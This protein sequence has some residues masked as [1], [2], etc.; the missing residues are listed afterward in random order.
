M[1][2]TL[3]LSIVFSYLALNL[4]SCCVTRLSIIENNPCTPPCWYNIIPGET[5]F[6]D[7]KKFVKNV[8]KVILIEPSNNEP[9]HSSQKLMFHRG[10]SESIVLLRFTKETVYQIEIGAE[11]WT[12]EKLFLLYGE[13]EYYVSYYEKYEM[14]NR[15]VL[16]IYTEK[17]MVVSVNV[18]DYQH[19][20][21]VE[22]NNSIEGKSPL[23]S[24]T[25]LPKKDFQTNW[26]NYLTG[27]GT[28]GNLFMAQ[29][30]KWEG[31]GELATFYLE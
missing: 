16:L 27:F 4:V 7:S 3:F 18:N 21:K 31:L 1:R 17:S 9:I 15:I 19:N 10:I 6:E 14:T 26:G 30:H 29:T 20:N 22:T 11:S 8:P 2:K 13:P 5:T 28:R 23:Y 24:V 25:F 12:V